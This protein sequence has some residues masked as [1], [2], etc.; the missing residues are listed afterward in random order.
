MK[1][2]NTFAI[3]KDS[4]LSVQY[5]TE[6]LHEFAK[7]FELWNDPI[8][9]REFFEKNKEDLDNEFWNGITIEEAI[10]KTREDASLFEEELLYI[11]E[12]GKTERLETLSTLFEPLSKGIIEENFEK[13]KAKGVKRRSWL[14]I[15]AIRIEANLFV[16]CGGAIKL[17]A[18][19]NE[20]PHLLLELEKL[21]F[22]RNY[23]QNGE[24]ENLDFVE[25]N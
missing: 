9:L 19:M 20:K 11:A 6:D 13:D 24:D 2:I 1:I 7:C 3:V 5:E 25:L 17:T 16:I 14:R 10:I 8:Y 15:Y 18:T 21:E 12:T 4:L 22:T 23:L